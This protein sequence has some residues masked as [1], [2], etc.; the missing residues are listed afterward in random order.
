MALL[1]VAVQ[2]CRTGRAGEHRGQFPGQVVHVLDGGVGPGRGHR[3]H[4]VRRVAD[5]EDPP[6]G[7]PVGHVHAGLPR[8]HADD[9]HGQV[10]HADDGA[11]QFDPPL[12][13]EV[14]GEPTVHNGVAGGEQPPVGAVDRH[15]AAGGDRVVD[16][17]QVE[18]P[19]AH[20]VGQVGAEVH[21]EVVGQAAEPAAR[22]AERLP[23]RTARAVSGDHVVGPH[24]VP[25]AAGPVHDRGGHARP[26]L[27]Q[28][29][30]FGGEPHVGA[31]RHGRLA[32]HRL[33][34]VLRA[35]HAGC[36]GVL[37]QGGVL[38]EAGG[39]VV[40]HL[41]R[42]G[43]G[44]GAADE[45]AGEVGQWGGRAL[46]PVDQAERA[47][48]LGA[49]RVEPPGLGLWRRVRMPL[50]QQGPHAVPVEQQRRGQPGHAA[51][52]DQHGHAFDS[53]QI[54]RVRRTLNVRCTRRVRCTQLPRGFW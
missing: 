54:L 33:Q 14:L 34:H 50:D 25:L 29:Q 13:F 16:R 37:T 10:G 21:V 38:G 3:R 19:A 44:Q 51:A 23:D 32:Q 41:R 17:A 45:H 11:Q 53:H 46:D 7:E 28:R 40:G 4:H 1:V 8:H 24:R 39:Q 18:L 47:E 42:P 30:Q 43:L 49:A 6:L 5:Q 20:Q 12:R 27:A 35:Q 48:H 9:L 36:R 22:N 31:A 26:V 2:Q 15:E 52:D